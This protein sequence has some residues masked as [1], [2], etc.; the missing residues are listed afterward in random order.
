MKLGF[1]PDPPAR[2][3]LRSEPQILPSTHGGKGKSKGHE[4]AHVLAAATEGLGG[5]HTQEAGLKA[6]EVQLDAAERF[7]TCETTYSDRKAYKSC[8]T[9]T[10]SEC[11]DYLAGL[12]SRVEDD[13]SD[14]VRRTYEERV[15]I[16]N[17]VDI[18][19]T[20]FLPLNFNGSMVGKFWG[21]VRTLIEVSQK[22]KV[23]ITSEF[24][25]TR[26]VVH[27]G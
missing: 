3:V 20:F 19:Y 13:G 6:L 17:A 24:I 26:E 18:V 21:A 22:N 8:E 16:F 15:D 23:Q 2:A 4:F 11:Y 14:I 5:F 9:A 12:A 25:L 7:L 10:R 27:I 1:L